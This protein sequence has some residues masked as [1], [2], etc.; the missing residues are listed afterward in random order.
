MGEGRSLDLFLLIAGRSRA[1]R[2]IERLSDR[3]SWQRTRRISF[4][5]N[6]VGHAGLPGPSRKIF[7]R[8]PLRRILHQRDFAS[9]K[10]AR[11]RAHDA[12]HL[13]DFH[14]AGPK[15]ILRERDASGPGIVRAGGPL[16][17]PEISGLGEKSHEKKKCDCFHRRSCLFE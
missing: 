14:F 2:L 13:P 3:N 4:E 5:V 8:D 9:L 17:S 12:F 6:G 1:V 16:L 10:K 7:E 15:T 11:L